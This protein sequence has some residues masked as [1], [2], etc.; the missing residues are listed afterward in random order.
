MAK[1]I[2]DCTASD[3][4]AMSSH[5]LFESICASEGRTI[6]A[7]TVAMS[8]P[9]I[10]GVSNPEVCVAFG[11]DMIV[12]NVYDVQKPIIVGVPPSKGE[13][14]EIIPGYELVGVGATINDLKRL[15][16]QP[17]GTKLEPVDP[18]ALV[19]G[20]RITVPSGRVFSIENMKL[21]MKQGADFIRIMGNPGSGCTY[22]TMIKAIRV[23]KKEFGD[24]VLIA[25]GKGHGMGVKSEM[26]FK[27]TSPERVKELI[28]A[29][30]DWVVLP[31][32][33]TTPGATVEFVRELA[34]VAHDNNV[35]ASS[36]MLTSQEGAD[37]DTI[38]RFGVYSKMTG[39][40][41]HHIGDAGYSGMAMPENI[42]ALSV[43]IRGRRHTYRRMA[44]SPIR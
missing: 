22:E 31:A 15:I 1:R 25:S 29:G 28:N 4:K 9:L 36:E 43:V 5:D 38:K 11:A 42:M 23:A 21:A 41:I 16:G 20:K 14:K 13:A 27:C 33:G 7:E 39:A 2:L 18:T 35:L 17:V 12:L 40:D 26:G 8:P 6:L 32:P 37:V 10:E 44:I 30:V 34:E 19:A 24:K 3:F